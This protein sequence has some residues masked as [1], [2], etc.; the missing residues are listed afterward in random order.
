[1]IH[2][3]KPTLLGAAMAALALI[4][5]ASFADVRSGGETITGDVIIDVEADEV[6]DAWKT[7]ATEVFELNTP[8]NVTVTACSDVDNPG[9]DLPNQYKFDITLDTEVAGL[10]SG[11][12][13]TVD[14][15]FND[16]LANDADVVQV[17]S[18]R[19]FPN[20][21]ANE[22]HSIRWMGAKTDED[23]EDVVVFDTSM[24]VQTAEG[25]QL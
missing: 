7:L 8:S 13:R 22:S 25:G 19:F 4:P 5:A 16:P 6:T 24:T 23:F 12:M 15:L 14:D 20:V 11:S 18:T 2:S 3:M 17:C 9:G 21:S 10:N 1:M